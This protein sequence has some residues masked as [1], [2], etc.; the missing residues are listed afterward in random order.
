MKAKEI[1]ENIY[2]KLVS[3]NYSRK[4]NDLASVNSLNWFDLQFELKDVINSFPI[5]CVAFNVDLMDIEDLDREQQFYVFISD[6]KVYLVDTQGYNYPRYIVELEGFDSEDVTEDDYI[7]R[8]EG[9]IRIAD[10]Q[11]FNAVVKSL[12]FELREEDF[13]QRDI[14]NFLQFKLDVAIEAA[15]K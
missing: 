5:R 3:L 10:D 13:S 1:K 8:M 6:G 15:S 2:E 7:D 4:E 14:L 11:I 9:L 12:V